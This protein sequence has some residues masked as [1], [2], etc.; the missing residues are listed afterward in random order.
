MLSGETSREGIIPAPVYVWELPVRLWHWINALSITTLA[1]TGFLIG[2]PLPSLTGEASDH[3]M[4]GEIRFLHFAAAYVFAIGFAL[5]I[6]WAIVGNV[7]SRE[8][9]LP[10]V[11]SP[12]FWR[13]ITAQLRW[14][15]FLKKDPVNFT[16]HNPLAQL[17]MFG[18]AGL[19]S[20][21]MILT[22]FALYSADQGAGSLTD[23]LFGWVVPL[24]GQLQDVRT[25]HHL[26]M[27]VILFFIAAHIYMAIHEDIMGRESMIG[28]MVNG[29]RT[30]RGDRRRS[31]R[32]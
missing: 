32:S 4:M 8:L 10:P 17:A 14:Y 30:F 15:L 29:W 26:G 13:G 12:V 28:T 22:G 1:V 11:L 3:F 20:L 23:R 19:G 9:F 18:F 27:W 6:L 5:R 25:W 2:S 21:F 31:G 7:Y 24:F 16:G